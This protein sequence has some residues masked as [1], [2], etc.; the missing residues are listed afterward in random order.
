MTRWVGDRHCA[1]S[2]YGKEVVYNV[3]RLVKHHVWDD[4]HMRT[5]T[6]MRTGTYEHTPTHTPS[7]EHTPTPPPKWVRS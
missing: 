6:H 2:M 7:H 1:I 3:N 4:V 5:D